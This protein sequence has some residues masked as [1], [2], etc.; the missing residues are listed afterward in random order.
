MRWFA[1]QATSAIG[2]VARS[3]GGAPEFDV[4]QSYVEWDVRVQPPQ[5]VAVFAA[6]RAADQRVEIEQAEAELSR[7]PGRRHEVVNR[8][9]PLAEA[10]DGRP[11]DTDLGLK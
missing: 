4:C 8:T 9:D 10:E 1:R 5:P 6:H 2:V 11:Q 3:G 7:H